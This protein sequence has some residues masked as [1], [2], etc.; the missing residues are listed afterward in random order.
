MRWIV[1]TEPTVEP[2]TLE[3]ARDHLGLTPYDSDGHPHDE[4][5]QGFISA[6]RDKA[7]QWCG[8]SFAPKTI[9]LAID[10][11]PDEIE[12]VSPVLEMLSVTYVDSDEVEQTV[13]TNEYVVDNYSRPA[14]LLPAVDESWP[15]TS[16]VVNAV[17]VRY[18]SGFLPSPDTDYPAGLTLPAS[19]KAAIKLILGALYEGRDTTEIPEAAKSLLRSYRIE[20][21]MA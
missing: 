19:V 4:M 14:W 15:A 7:E 21:G 9:E 8:M 2:L 17:R 5:V 18:V 13:A 10:T 20:L 11:F 3:E 16:A 12:L 6:A 1:V